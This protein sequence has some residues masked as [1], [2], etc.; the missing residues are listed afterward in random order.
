MEQEDLRQ[1]TMEEAVDQQQKIL[2]QIHQQQGERKNEEQLTMTFIAKLGL[3]QQEQARSLQ[4]V[5]LR[6]LQ[7]PLTPL[8]HFLL[9]QCFLL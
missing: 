4:P 1:R 5:S 9:Q 7:A 3:E 6:S 2:D 8:W